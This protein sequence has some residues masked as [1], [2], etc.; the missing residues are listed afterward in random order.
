MSININMS[1]HHKKRYDRFIESLKNRENFLDVYEVH[2]IIPKCLGGTDDND[3]LIKLTPREHFLAHLMLHR[4]Y[5]DSVSL[6]K[7]LQAMFRTNFFTHGARLNG[8]KYDQMRKYAFRK[9]TNPP[10]SILYEEYCVKRKSL[11]QISREFGVSE[12][13]V[14][15]WYA[16]TFKNFKPQNQQEFVI[17]P[18]AELKQHLDNDKYPFTKTCKHYNCSF[19]LMQ[20]WR[21]KYNLRG[22]PGAY[23]RVKKT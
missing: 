22:K 14:K 19:P 16:H 15:K 10:K 20:K 4:I 7:A 23:K 1:I 6:L 12:P 18:R 2:H 9:T 17:P 3:N 21:G 8:R 11:A 5:P 13:T